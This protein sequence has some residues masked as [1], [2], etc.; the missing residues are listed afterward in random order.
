MWQLAV[1]D[2]RRGRDPDWLGIRRMVL[3][4]PPPYADYLDS[5]INFVAEK[6]G[7]QEGERLQDLVAFWRDHI[8]PTVRKRLPSQVWDAL[9]NC[10][11]FLLSLALFKAAYACP[12]AEV[13]HG[14]CSWLRASDVQAL[15][16][17]GAASAEGAGEAESLLWKVRA[18]TKPA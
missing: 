16:R 13:R 15:S 14:V 1:Q 3:R 8:N 5:L 4:T 2:M 12:L 11:L 10:K 18:A 17:S 6:A 7:G 9:A